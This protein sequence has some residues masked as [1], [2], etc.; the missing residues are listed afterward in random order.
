MSRA[1]GNAGIKK[2]V[3]AEPV[4][5][6]LDLAQVGA[7]IL[8]SDGLT[9][10]VDGQ[11]AVETVQGMFK[12][13]SAT[14]S[15]SS[16]L[17]PTGKAMRGSRARRSSTSLN[18]GDKGDVMTTSDAIEGGGAAGDLVGLGGLEKSFWTRKRRVANA[19]TS[20]A[21]MRQS[22]DNITVLAFCCREIASTAAIQ[23]SGLGIS[24]LKSKMIRSSSGD[25]TTKAVRGMQ[26]SMNTGEISADVN[27]K[28]GQL[29]EAVMTRGIGNHSVASPSSSHKAKRP[30]GIGGT[31]SS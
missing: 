1:F 28:L 18:V 5:T 6:E 20:L 13:N 26:T 9:D 3:K 24:T 2:C 11:K 12:G 10:V 4:V 7:C 21:K 31:I 30:K 27:Q 19:L 22:M 29:N 14:P 15:K 16:F 17:S 8:C 23:S 25:A